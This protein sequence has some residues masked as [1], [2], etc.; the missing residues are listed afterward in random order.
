MISGFD[1]GY[2]FDTGSLLGF[3]HHS[4][5]PVDLEFVSLSFDEEAYN[6][7]G[8][9]KAYFGVGSALVSVECP[10]KFVHRARAWK[11]ERRGSRQWT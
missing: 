1:G 4:H 10:R 6:T 7:L 11:I 8:T 9:I 5:Q 3:S 2:D